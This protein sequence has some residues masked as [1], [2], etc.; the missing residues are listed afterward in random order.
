MH[1]SGKLLKNRLR[2]YR[3]PADP[4]RPARCREAGVTQDGA[5]GLR[6]VPDRMWTSEITYL[7]T[8]QCW[9]HLLRGPRC[10]LAAV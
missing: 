5:G 4:G 10:L 3:C 2:T 6:Q 9:L 1:I 8:G 7:R